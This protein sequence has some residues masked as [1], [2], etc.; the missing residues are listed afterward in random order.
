M[1]RGKVR[2]V[3]T[4]D[5]EIVGRWYFLFEVTTKESVDEPAGLDDKWHRRL[6]KIAGLDASR[7]ALSIIP[8]E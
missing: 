5:P 3:D 6:C 1:F 7:F 8:E 4:E 2:V